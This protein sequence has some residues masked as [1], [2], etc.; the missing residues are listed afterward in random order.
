MPILKY[1]QHFSQKTAN[2]GHFA[3]KSNGS[4]E[5]IGIELVYA[6]LHAL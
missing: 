1:L 3:S 6:I 5:S 4:K 2:W